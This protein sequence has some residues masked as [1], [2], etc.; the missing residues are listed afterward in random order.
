MPSGYQ[1]SAGARAVLAAGR[2]V[3]A[4]IPAWRRALAAAL[5]EASGPTPDWAR[6]QRILTNPDTDAL[7]DAAQKIVDAG[8][9]TEG[10]SDAL[11]GEH[12]GLLTR[13][14]NDT[15]SRWSESLTDVSNQDVAAL[16][17]DLAAADTVLERTMQHALFL[18]FLNDV[19]AGRM[20]Q[21]F[22]FTDYCTGWGLSATS[23][24]NLWGWLQQDPRQFDGTDLP[25]VLDTV[26]RCAYRK[27]ITTWEKI[28][29]T[30]AALWGAALVFVIVAVLFTLLHAA[31]VTKWPGS[32]AWKLLVLVLFTS[33]GAL[34]H[35]G[36]QAL[37][38]KYS[39][40]MKVYDAGNIFDWLSLRWIAIVRL[41][42]PVGFVVATLWGA[43]NIPTSFRALST[44]LLAGYS[45]DSLL[46]A[47][48]SKL[49]SQ[50]AKSAPAAN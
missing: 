10:G 43:G 11:V 4:C 33:V 44:A 42:L 29:S 36:A 35:V 3:R 34:A 16:K 47:A 25:V 21:S 14:V 24:D 38:V 18:T 8:D 7:H 32:W 23:L 46:G 22:P 5:A 6:L 37:N 19:S 26:N 12:A 15:A 9:G 45:A 17:T 13:A 41:Y 20:C 48:I 50:A 28:S 1:V 49:K 40:P 31:Q 2:N 27:A 30:S 39:D